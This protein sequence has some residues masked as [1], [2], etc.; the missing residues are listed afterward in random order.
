MKALS[1]VALR[2][3]AM[4]AALA[5]V[6]PPVIAASTQEI[7]NYKGPDRQKM[8]EEG[9]RKEGQ[10]TIYSA[11]TINQALRPLVEGFQKKYPYIKAEFWRGESRKIAQKVLAEQRAKAL[12]AGIIEGSGLAEIMSAAKAV[13]TFTTPALNNIPEIYHDPAREWVPSRI[14]YFGI[15]YNTK[16]IPPGTQPKTYEELADPKWQG[17]LAW[18]ADSESGSQGFVTAMRLAM[19]EAKAEAFLKKLS[20]QKIVNFTGSARTL[21]NR[22]IEGEYPVAINI[23]MHHPVISAG[24]G[25]PVASHPLEPVP[26]LIG[27]MQI[28]KGVKQPHAAM[29]FVDF[30]LSAEGQ[31]IMQKAQ[32]FPVHK[33]V[34]PVKELEQVVPRLTGKKEIFV[35]PENLFKNRSSSDAL[36]AKYF[37]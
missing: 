29:L 32:Y 19:G 30:Y 6:V 24:Q 23:F 7:L 16:L 28:P 9:A 27:T 21:V 1:V 3:I 5:M 4:G 18:R 15:A 10:L 33:D 31:T 37:K 22:T 11:L 36:I 14:S 12:V 26:S 17:K 25:A 20:T 8:L 13:E 2:L 34:G 35:S